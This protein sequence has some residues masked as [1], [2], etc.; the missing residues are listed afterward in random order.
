MRQKASL[1][2]GHAAVRDE[3]PQKQGTQPQFCAEI[4]RQHSLRVWE[5]GLQMAV[6]HE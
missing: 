4:R 3:A 2:R 6:H 1:D 5:R